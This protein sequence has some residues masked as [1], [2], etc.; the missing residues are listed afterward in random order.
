MDQAIFPT[1]RTFALWRFIAALGIM[2]YHLAHV[3]PGTAVAIPFFEQFNPMLDMFFVVS[4]FLI[5]QRYRHKVGSIRDY[6]SYLGRRLVRIYPLHLVTFGFFV[7]IGIAFEL[8]II[9]SPSGAERYDWSHF[10][11]NLFLLQAWGIPDELTFNYVSWSLS[12]EWFCYLLLPLLVCIAARTGVTGLAIFLGLFVVALEYAVATGIMKERAWY[13]AKTWGAYRAFADFTL[14]VIIL[15]VSERSSWRL[16]SHGAGW[17][18]MCVALLA[19]G[20]NLSFYLNMALLSTALYLSALAE[21]ENE[22]GTRWLDPAMPVL[23]VSFGVYLWHP[24]VI[25]VMNSLVWKH[26]LADAGVVGLYPYL[27]L[28]GLLSVAAAYVSMHFV[29]RRMSDVIRKW[30]TGAPPA[31]PAARPAGA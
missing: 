31:P 5:Y 15:H 4:G 3:S 28:V 14:G 8:D 23:G 29:E 22:E 10:F 1:Y 27:V 26:L 17:A 7:A 11:T 25:T 30:M 16:R 12:A 2:V 9:H 20:L 19:M 18:V 13:D 21:K 24:V 6:L